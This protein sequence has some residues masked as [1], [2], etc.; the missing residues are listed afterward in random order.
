MQ[1]TLERGGYNVH[2]F[3]KK[4]SN[5]VSKFMH[6]SQGKYNEYYLEKLLINF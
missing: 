4:P 6:G 3:K 1:M 2:A 5:F